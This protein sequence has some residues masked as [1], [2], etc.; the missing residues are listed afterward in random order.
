MHYIQN[1]QDSQ[2]TVQSVPGAV[3]SEVKRLEREA[4]NS[5]AHTGELRNGGALRPLP[6]TS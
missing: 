6:N 1:I 4:D 2:P 3:S 5:P